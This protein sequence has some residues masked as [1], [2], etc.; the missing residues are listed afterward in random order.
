MKKLLIVMSVFVFFSVSA[1]AETLPV[2]ENILKKS[3]GDEIDRQKQAQIAQIEADYNAQK[4][5]I[6][7]TRSAITKFKQ[8]QLDINFARELKSFYPE[9][10][11]Y[12][13]KDVRNCCDETDTCHANAV[14]LKHRYGDKLG[15]TSCK[16]EKTDGDQLMACLTWRIAKDTQKYSGCFAPIS[17]YQE[18]V[19]AET[20]EMPVME[21][22]PT[23][24]P[25][26]NGTAVPATTPAEKKKIA[27]FQKM[28]EGWKRVTATVFRK[29]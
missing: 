23:S 2:S 10:A 17:Y 8:Y 14:I 6:P 1:S 24:T 9:Y 7:R 16:Q 4:N 22:T 11:A 26:A 28:K 12:A 19:L 13:I 25:S 15:V 3:V 18:K 27:P 5:A 29:S 20:G 21:S